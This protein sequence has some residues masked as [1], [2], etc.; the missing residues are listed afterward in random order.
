M[1]RLTSNRL[2]NRALCCFLI[3]QLVN[4]ACATMFR[5]EIKGLPKHFFELDL[6]FFVLPN[7]VENRPVSET[8]FSDNK[9]I[10]YSV[11]QITNLLYVFF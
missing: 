3:A 8:F 1:H 9:L 11:H 4:L 5:Y 6:Y 7:P 2:R 10:G